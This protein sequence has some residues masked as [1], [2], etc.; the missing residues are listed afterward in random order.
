MPGPRC[1]VL[2]MT[3]DVLRETG[4]RFG[5]SLWLRKVSSSVKRH[6]QC[7][8][9]EAQPGS[10]TRVRSVAEDFVRALAVPLPYG[11]LTAN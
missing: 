4:S 3:P 11:I 10:V 9:R 1:S 5:N 8:R 6:S 7:T 2:G